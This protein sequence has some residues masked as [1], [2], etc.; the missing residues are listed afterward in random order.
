MKY[1]FLLVAFIIVTCSSFAQNMCT[2]SGTVQDAKTGEVMIG[3]IIT[4]KELSGTGAAT[5][6]YGFYS[7]SVKP[8]KYTVSFRYIGYADKD[9]LINLQKSVKW[10]IDLDESGTT[11]GEVVVTADRPDKNITSSQM[12]VDK[13]SVKEISDIPVLFGEKDILKT[14]QLLPGIKAV[15]EGNS[16]IYVRGGGA[17]QNLVLLDEANVYNPS[18]VLGF[19]SVFN[20]DAIK[21]VTVYKG[22]IPAEYGGRISSVLD[23][24][25]N[26]GDN[27]EF[28]TTGG[29]GLIDSRLTFEGPIKKNKSSFIVSAR[30]TYADLFL[31]I[32]GPSNLRNTQLYFYDVN[33]KANYEL[34]ANDR[35]FVSGYFGR[36]A[37]NFN[38]NTNSNQ[39]FGINWGN[40]T[41]TLRWNHLFTDKL[42]LNSSFVYSNYSNDITIG[43]S[44]AQF[45]I[46]TGIRDYSLKEDFQYYISP[47]NTLKFGGQ[48]IFH[49]FIPGEITIN[50]GS[51][52]L[53]RALL[54]NTVQR[55]HALESA[56]YMSDDYTLSKKITVTYGLRYSL[57]TQLGPGNIYSYD[58]NGNVI[59]SSMYST[60]QAVKTYAGIEP[61]ISAVYILNPASSIKASYNHINQYL[62]LLSN[63]T[64]STPVDLW[65]PASAIVKP[66]IGDQEDIGYFRNFKDNT[67]ESSVE[68]YY[69]NMQNQID[70]KDGANLLFNKEIESQLLFGRGWA[71]GAE[72][73]LKKKYG[74]LNGWVGY[75][76]SR[77]FREFDGIDNGVPFPARQDII[78]DVSIVGIYDYSKKWTFSATFVYY[79]GSSVTFPS[80]KYE[81]DGN[82]LSLYTSRNGYRMPPYNRLD[83]GVT[84]ITKKTAKREASWNFS[85]YNVYARENAFSIYFQPDPNDATKTQAVQLSLFRFV[86]SAT[87]NFKF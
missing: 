52:I 66:Q 58:A 12:S 34:G 38:N 35:V 6:A 82:I 19:F 77:T 84:L 79:T 7:L 22:G 73:F 55:E 31:K 29:I 83:V 9:T 13:L 81:V 69:K 76:W 74:R 18:H 65:V 36:D 47:K 86:P 85:I 61:R 44:D 40:T 33:V 68:V 75:T 67:Y 16:G 2:L 70:Y 57:F 63:T 59:D 8:G 53:P 11:L 56:L 1:Y 46:I 27:K 10:K 80:G 32:L 21:D 15:T 26:D 24:K 30:R 41:G 48:S 42:F 78:H 28:K 71:Y 60:N 17:D 3:V 54:S 62:Q 87:Y 43:A 64:V 23:I 37:F 39:N 20:S 50:T 4:I 25:M 51:A 45:M 49:T 14:L 5:N 72:F